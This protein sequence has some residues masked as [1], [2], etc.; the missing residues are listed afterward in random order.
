M[1]INFRKQSKKIDEIKRDEEEALAATLAEKLDLPYTDLSIVPVHAEALARIPEEKA[2]EA[3]LATFN[4]QGKHMDVAILTPNNKN[5]KSIIDSLQK[6]GLIVKLHISSKYGLEKAWERYKEIQEI[7]VTDA[8]AIDVNQEKL[9]ELTKDLH[10]LEDVQ[11]HAQKE[12][13]DSRTK[14]TS[15]ILEIIIAGALATDA[16]DIHIEPEENIVRLRLRLDGVLQDISTFDRNIYK[17]LLSRVKLVSGL[18]LNIRDRGQDGRFSINIGDDDVEIRTSVLPGNYGESVVL[19]ILNPNTVA[20]DIEKLGMNKKVLARM[21]EEIKKPDGIILN[22]GPTGSGKTT[23]LYSF[24]KLVNRP[25]IKII[26][27]EDPIEY[28]IEGIT[29]TQVRPN[30]TFLSGLRSSLRQDPDIIM[31][32]EIRDAETA[33]ISINSSLTGHLVFSTLHTNN[34]AGTIPRLLDLGVDAKIIGEAANIMMAQRLVR[35]LCSSC[36]EEAPATKEEIEII[37]PFVDSLPEDFKGDVPDLSKLSLYHHKGCKECNGMGYRGRIG[38]FEIIIVDET[39]SAIIPSHP[40][41][42]G[43]WEAAKKQGIPRIHEDGILKVIAGI[44]DL[45]ELSRVVDLDQ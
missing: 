30:Y 36:K 41:E 4:E 38:I 33:R 22:T 13:S 8:G 26:T 21:R 25:G 35:I 5:V 29:Q 42:R 44:T 18:K 43:I 31:I 23:T 15:A 10:S 11:A 40:S 9:D 27:I 1:A 28:H 3:E 37:Q 19:R 6:E 17:F 16:S 12:L 32:G 20:L 34:A 24:L 39:I 14:N 7:D 45:T 2:R